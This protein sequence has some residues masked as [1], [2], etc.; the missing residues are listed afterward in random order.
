MMRLM[1]RALAR[2]E[3]PLRFS[4]GFNPRP[5]LSLPLPRPVGVAAVDDLM[6]TELD[7]PIDPGDIP[8]RLARQ[9]PE[10]VDPTRSE[11][12]TDPA[13]VYPVRAELSL[14]IEPNQ[15]NRLQQKLDELAG[16]DAWPTVRPGGRGK[17]D[18]TLDLRPLVE[19]AGLE[20]DRLRI[21]LVPCRQRW[22]RVQELLHLLDL[23]EQF[24]RARLVRS[25]VAWSSQPP[26]D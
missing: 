12:L 11:L 4:Q 17:Q 5:R 15:R 1:T 24:D 13:G 19:Q 7:E 18:R 6:V 2:A 25:N 22:A 8:G 26:Q 21:V 16:L 9:T 3:A 23:D 10:G 14:Q 20:D